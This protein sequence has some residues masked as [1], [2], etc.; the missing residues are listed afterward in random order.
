MPLRSRNL[1]PIFGGLRSYAIF[2]GQKGGIVTIKSTSQHWF[3]YR[4]EAESAEK[5]DNRF[6][7]LTDCLL[8]FFVVVLTVAFIVSFLVL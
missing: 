6:E 2:P 1:R 8:V 5:W 3:R 4:S 7:I